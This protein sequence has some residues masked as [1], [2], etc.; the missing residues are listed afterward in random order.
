MTLPRSTKPEPAPLPGPAP[1]AGAQWEEGS[2]E[3]SDGLSLHY[4]LYGAAAGA[5]IVLL[6]GGPG[7]SFMGVGPDL[8][9]LSQHGPFLQYDQRGGGRSQRD[10]NAASQTVETHVEDLETLRIHFGYECMVLVGHSWGCTLGAHYAQRYPERVAR[11]I[12]IGPMEPNRKLL[13]QR[14]QLAAKAN[15]KAISEIEALDELKGDPIALCRARMDPA[16]LLLPR[17]SEDGTQEG[18]LL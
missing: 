16:T 4:R 2:V 17:C 18:R 1:A 13:R 5:P 3:T 14:I 11:M 8:V 6:H 15:P 10:P 7:Q 12:L 9:P